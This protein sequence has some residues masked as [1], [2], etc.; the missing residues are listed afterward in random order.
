MRKFGKKLWIGILLF[1]AAVLCALLFMRKSSGEG[2][3]PGG[4]AAGMGGPDQ[5][6]D[7]QQTEADI[8]SAVNPSTGSIYIT[9]GLTGTLE[10]SDVVYVYAKASG[11]V[12]AVHVKAGDEVTA[13]QVL[14]EID[15]DQVDTAK[16]S[17]D[18]ASVSLSQARSNLER[19]KILYDGG[20]LSEQEYEQYQNN[21]KSAELQYSSA[22]LAYDK[23]VEYSKVTAPISGRIESCGTEVYDRVSANAEL[24][25]IS[26]EGNKKI[27][28]YVTQRM[29]ENVSEGD[30]LT[31]EKNGKS[32]DAHISAINS[33]VDSATG[34][35]KLEAQLEDTEE[36]ATGTVVKLEVTT[37]KAEN[38]MLIPID[39]IY[40]SGGDAYVYLYEDGTA[41][42]AAI[43]VGL[44]DGENAEVLSGLSA[45]DLVIKSWSSNLYEGA[46]IRLNENTDEDTAGD[47]AGA[48]EQE[49]ETAGQSE[50]E[51]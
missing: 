26:G 19:M 21:V 3:M 1:I 37:D 24:C 33:M 5:T 11:D 50:V 49:P 18:T 47:S 42:M 38:V 4:K 16:N 31:V 27:T 13:G 2:G 34:L 46:K 6:P 43:E 39:S 8:V 22:K 20:D 36:V 28:F 23:Q 14:F 15:T 41:R 32:Y 7:G 30:V 44:T 51:G 45:E 25:V 35:F 40:Y 17:L 10:S 48:P 12:T 9:T 29:L